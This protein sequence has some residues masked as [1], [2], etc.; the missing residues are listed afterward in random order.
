LDCCGPARRT[1]RPRTAVR[2][3]AVKPIIDVLVT[4]D[5]VEGESRY[6]PTL[7]ACGYVLRVR[8]PDHRMF[9]TPRRDG[10]VHLW[11]SGSEEERRQLLFRDWLR[12]NATD[13]DLYERTKRELSRRFWTDMNYYAEAKSAVIAAILQRAADGPVSDSAH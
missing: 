5:D 3:L 11:R 7:E 10:H 6:R 1:F 4:L 13:R 12:R 9:R 8:E 2:G